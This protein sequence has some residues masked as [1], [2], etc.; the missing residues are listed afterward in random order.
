LVLMRAANRRKPAYRAAVLVVRACW[1]H[2]EGAACVTACFM[3]A[4]AVLLW[5]FCVR[6][7]HPTLDPL[8][9]RP[10][11][12]LSVARVPAARAPRAWR[13]SWRSCRRRGAGCSGSSRRRG[14]R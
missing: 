10:P 3:C 11:Q 1:M 9:R 4:C 6:E 8:Q 7:R 13:S 14:R 12:R 2:G 5:G